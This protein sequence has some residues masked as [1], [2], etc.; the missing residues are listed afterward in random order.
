[1]FAMLPILL[2]ALAAQPL[3]P[4]GKWSMEYNDGNCTLSRG[5]GDPAKPTV[6][7]FK[8]YPQSIAGDLALVVPERDGIALRTGMGTIT[9][10]PGGKPYPAVWLSAPTAGG[11]RRAYRF[12]VNQSFWEGLVTAKVITFDPGGRPPVTVLL[13]PTKSALAALKACGDDLLRHWGAD[14]SAMILPEDLPGL[15]KWFSAAEYP[16]EALLTHQQGRVIPLTRFSPDGAPEDCRV[17]Q[18]SGVQSLDKQTCATIMRRSHVR[19]NDPGVLQKRFMVLPVRWI[20][21]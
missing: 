16:G 21:P 13:G 9:M 3:Q 4:V 20:M 14:P 6:F 10:E 12:E 1:M 7:G 19:A 2:S 15:L 17:V 5:F 8:P 11:K 18:T